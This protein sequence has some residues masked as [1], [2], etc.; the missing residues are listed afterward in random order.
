MGHFCCFK[1][2]KD[3]DNE[4]FDLKFSL[5]GEKHYSLEERKSED[6]FST[7]QLDKGVGIPRGDPSYIIFDRRL[8]QM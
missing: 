6:T 8:S 3:E 1:Y 2:Q 5:F 4:E 7:R